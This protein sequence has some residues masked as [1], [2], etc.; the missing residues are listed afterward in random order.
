MKDTIDPSNP[1][2]PTFE[3]TLS[4]L[5]IA[6]DEYAEGEE[7]YLDRL[8]MLIRLL[9]AGGSLPSYDMVTVS[10]FE[11]DEY[12]RAD[13]KNEWDKISTFEAKYFPNRVPPQSAKYTSEFVTTYNAIT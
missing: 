9:V 5:P 13:Y 10:E 11:N 1:S 6:W 8:H 12:N 4:S 7:Y 2:S 3:K